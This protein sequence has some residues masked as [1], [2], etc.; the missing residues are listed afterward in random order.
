MN[1]F[2]EYADVVAKNKENKKMLG[3]KI[4]TENGY[5][6]TI[7]KVKIIDDKDIVDRELTI[8]DEPMLNVSGE[9]L[10]Y[11]SVLVD[12][13]VRSGVYLSNLSLI[14]NCKCFK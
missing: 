1:T 7:N 10:M 6:T 2:Y 4:Q 14:K 9:G 3:M 8:K 13:I 5:I 12:S 11:V